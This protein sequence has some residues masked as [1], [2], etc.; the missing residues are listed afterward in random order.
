MEHDTLKIEI[1][2]NY[3]KATMFPIN[4]RQYLVTYKFFNPLMDTFIIALNEKKNILKS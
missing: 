2:R 3:E 1:K 4:M